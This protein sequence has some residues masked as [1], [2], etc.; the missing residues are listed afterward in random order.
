[1]GCP[2]CGKKLRKDQYYCSEECVDIADGEGPRKP[3]GFVFGCDSPDTKR[4]P[5]HNYMSN[6][7]RRVYRK[8]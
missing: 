4:D 8:D 1:M 2:I 7:E 6:E 3:A 5:G